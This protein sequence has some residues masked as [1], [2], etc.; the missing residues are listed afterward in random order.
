MR[1]KFASQ[2]FGK[3]MI[4]MLEKTDVSTLIM[5]ALRKLVHTSSQKEQD[6]EVMIRYAKNCIVALFNV[7]V[8]SSDKAVRNAASETI[9]VSRHCPPEHLS[10]RFFSD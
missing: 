9:K 5:A 3:L 8:D 7:Y 10:K 6:K 4:T 2:E 1:L